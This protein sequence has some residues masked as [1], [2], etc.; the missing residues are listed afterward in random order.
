MKRLIPML[1]LMLSLF[2]M[3][4]VTAFAADTGTPSSHVTITV[5][6]PEATAQPVKDEELKSPSLPYI[7]ELDPNPSTTPAPVEAPILYP[8]GVY[9]A[10]E[11][12]IKWIVKT[13]ELSPLENPA[14]IPRDSFERDGWRYTITDITKKETASADVRDHTETVTLNTDTKEMEVILRQL[15]KTM[16]FTS[17]DGYAGILDLNVASIKVETAG[18]KTT[19]YEM[20]VTREYPHLSTNDTELVPKTVTENGKTYKLASV[21]W[22]VGN[23]STVDYD[24]IP[25]YYTAYATYTATGS[26]TKVTG[27]TTTV[28]YVGTLSKL[29]QGKTVYTAYFIGKEIEPERIPLEIIQP[30]PTPETS[31]V[32]ETEP[33]A[34]SSE[35]PSATEQPSE[36]DAP[37]EQASQSDANPWPLIVLGCLLLLL[38]GVGAGYYIPKFKNKST[39]KGES[40]E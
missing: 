27:Y 15:A 24:R 37:V 29:N 28:E 40:D 30:S 35:Q 39:K 21:D 7:P 26:S 2:L 1:L 31:P 33:D 16:E 36:T 4:S 18:T 6:M 32:P 11:N 5:V 34:D 12:G 13:Y 22:Q 25:D 14:N 9:D 10:L 17:E 38:L 20:K 8:T 3:S 19:S 23:Y